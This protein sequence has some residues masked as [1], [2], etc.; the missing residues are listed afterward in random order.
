MFGTE[1]AA[2]PGTPYY[3]VIF[4]SVKN[5]TSAGYDDMAARML[6]L[7][8]SQEG[9]LGVESA[10]NEIGI[11]VSYWSSLSAIKKWK[12]NTDHLLAQKLGRDEWYAA[13]RVRI[14]IIE[15][16]YGFEQ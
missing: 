5:E 16:D 1:I 3:A 4:T 8:A 15:H 10:R 12:S 14:C 6:D 11:T 9:F 7:A 2:T 13:Y